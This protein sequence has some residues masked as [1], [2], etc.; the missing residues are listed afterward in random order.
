MKKRME[1][2]KKWL[3]SCIIISIVYTTFSYIL[4]WFDKNTVE[5]LTVEISGITSELSPFIDLIVSDDI[6]TS[7][8]E[9][10]QWAYIIKTTTGNNIITFRCNK[11]KPIIE[12]NFK[13]KVV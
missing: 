6:V 11:T 13:V 2:S 12:L 8:K 7:D 1:F 3:I 9:M 10:T 4:A 5:T